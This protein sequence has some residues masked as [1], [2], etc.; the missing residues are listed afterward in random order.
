MSKGKR[1][2][3]AGREWTCE[4]ECEARGR[5]RGREVGKKRKR[6][7]ERKKARGEMS[8]VILLLAGLPPAATATT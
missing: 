2:R 4:E 7:M 6:R 5:R 1:V 3:G 8:V